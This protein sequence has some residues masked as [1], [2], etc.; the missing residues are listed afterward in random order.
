MDLR[1][2]PP[3][4]AAEGLADGELQATDGALV[5]LGLSRGGGQLQLLPH[6]PG[7]LVA[8]SMPSQRLKRREFPAASL[9][10]EHTTGDGV[11]DGVCPRFPHPR[12]KHQAV[13][14]GQGLNLVDPISSTSLHIIYLLSS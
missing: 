9:A 2:V 3:H 7:L 1:A 14:H 8:G 10:L 6:Q 5:S 13:G 12:Q 4:V 11:L